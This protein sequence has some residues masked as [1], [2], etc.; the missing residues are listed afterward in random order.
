[1]TQN[2]WNSTIPVGVAKG[3]TGQS[4]YTDGELLI[5]NT[6]GNT[7]T[8]T[9]LTAG[10]G[11]SIT[12]GSGSI[13]ITNTGGGAPSPLGM[14]YIYEDFNSVGVVANS[15]PTTIGIVS[16]YF[17]D[18]QNYYNYIGIP[19]YEAGHPG[20]MQ[21][22]VDYGT[23]TITMPATLIAAVD[24]AFECSIIMKSLVVPGTGEGVAMRIQIGLGSA[25]LLGLGPEAALFIIDNNEYSNYTW[26]IVS[27]TGYTTSTQ[28]TSVALDLLWHKYTIKGNAAGTSLSF[29]IDEVEVTGSPITT[30]IFVGAYPKIYLDMPNIPTGDNP[31]IDLFY[32]TQTLTTSR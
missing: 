22:N 1:M 25:P 11:I 28:D 31:Y 6:T 30:N 29:Y 21:M 12:P 8:K 9:S 32:L 18:T 14:Q 24:G 7:L 13:T 27:S 26:H 17:W 20:I 5:G 19:T 23:E 3:G 4:S 10:T 15:T 16:N 2:T